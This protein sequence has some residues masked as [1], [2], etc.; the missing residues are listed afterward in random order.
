M[1]RPDGTEALGDGHLGKVQASAIDAVKTIS[2]GNAAKLPV[3]IIGPGMVRTDED[4]VA[5]AGIV[6]QL[7]AAVL[8]DV[9]EAPQ[10]ALLVTGQ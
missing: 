9:E 4:P 5:P 3:R 2:V 10:S 1:A 8:A 6:H 7:G